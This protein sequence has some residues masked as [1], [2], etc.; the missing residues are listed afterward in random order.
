MEIMNLFHFLNVQDIF[1]ASNYIHFPWSRLH[2]HR[3][4]IFEN[5]HCGEDTQDSEDNSANRVSNVCLRVEIDDN[6]RDHYSD[7]L[8]NITN[9]V[10]DGSPNIHV[11]MTVPMMTM[12]MAV[13]V[14]MTM[15]MSMIMMIVFVF[16][17]IM[18]VLVVMFNFFMGVFAPFAMVVLVV[19][20]T[21]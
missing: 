21:R 14:T 2:Q 15:T 3:H 12:S 5:G 1:K 6:S 4:A 16:F 9:N 11:F 19:V 17:L 18:I 13:S 10:D 7:T 20:T 8:Y